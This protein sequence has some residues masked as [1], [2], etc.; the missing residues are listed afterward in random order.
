MV[1][2]AGQSVVPSAHQKLKK[3]MSHTTKMSSQRRWDP[4]RNLRQWSLAHN[5]STVGGK[6]LKRH[7]LGLFTSKTDLECW[8]ANVIRVIC[9]GLCGEAIW[10]TM[11]TWPKSWE[12]SCDLKRTG[13]ANEKTTFEL[14]E[15]RTKT[16]ECQYKTNMR[17]PKPQ[18]NATFIFTESTKCCKG[19]KIWI[20][21][22]AWINK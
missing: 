15:S 6:V 10:A 3:I 2:R 5:V 18:R 20:W 13:R 16:C 7:C 4:G 22:N 8:K 21:R 11:P 17:V 12:R 19:C 9:L 1:Q 14:G